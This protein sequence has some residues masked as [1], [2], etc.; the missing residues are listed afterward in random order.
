LLG[1]VVS[2]IAAIFGG[3]GAKSISNIKARAIGGPVSAGQPYLVGERGPELMVPNAPGTIIPNQMLAHGTGPGVA[4][5]RLMLSGDIDARIQRVS[6][7]VAV[8]VVRASAP[9]II[10]ASANET[11]RRAGRPTL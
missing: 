8:E 6:G 11:M 1:G 3:G 7:P 10:D 2:G 5:V 9:T 4:T